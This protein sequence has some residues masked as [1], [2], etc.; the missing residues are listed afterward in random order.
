MTQTQNQSQNTPTGIS[1]SG[2]Y[3]SFQLGSELYG[4]AIMSVREIIALLDITP[5]PD[6]PHYV[7]GVI[8]L[9]GRIIPVVDLRAR[10]G[11]ASVEH[12]EK[13]CIV[14]IEVHDADDDEIMQVGCIVDSVNEVMDLEDEQIETTLEFAQLSNVHAIKGLAKLEK[15][16]DVLALL[17]IHWVLSNLDEA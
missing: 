9:R 2:K 8:N 11:L 6:V 7:R 4:V 14:V 10:L 1:M 15:S 3:L 13:T 12:T 16:D 17:D 5:L